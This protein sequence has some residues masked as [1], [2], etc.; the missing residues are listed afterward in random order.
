MYAYQDQIIHFFIT[1]YV[2]IYQL[3]WRLIFQR[4]KYYWSSIFQE[5]SLKMQMQVHDAR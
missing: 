2:N 3:L 4:R 5:T 1:F